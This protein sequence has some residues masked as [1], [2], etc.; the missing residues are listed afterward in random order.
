MEK[1]K[2]LQLEGKKQSRQKKQ[3]GGYDADYV[4]VQKFKHSALLGS[5]AGF[6]AK[7]HT[8]SGLYRNICARVDF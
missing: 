6:D 1:V 2:K 3:D 4:V 5:F 7:M 8:F